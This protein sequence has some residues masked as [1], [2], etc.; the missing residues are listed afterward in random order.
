[1]ADVRSLNF[2][3]LM[4]SGVLHTKM[5]IVDQ[6]NV[7]IGSA[8]MDWRSLTEVKVGFEPFYPND[9]KIEHGKI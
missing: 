2:T 7:Y 3:A 5:W 1:V 9:V 4:G 6:K 8:N